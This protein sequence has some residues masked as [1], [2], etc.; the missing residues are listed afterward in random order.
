MRSKLVV[1]FLVAYPG[2]TF[3]PTIEMDLFAHARDTEPHY[4]GSH[5]ALAGVV[6]FW[7]YLRRASDHID[8]VVTA[9]W[10]Q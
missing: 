1:C 5:I 3:V 6:F 10:W 9:E 8:D 4:D 2:L 7:W